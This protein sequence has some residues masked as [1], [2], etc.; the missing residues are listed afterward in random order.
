L[1]EKWAKADSDRRL[2]LCKSDV[3]TRLDHWPT[4]RIDYPRYLRGDD[5]AVNRDAI[6]S[7]GQGDLG[8][9]GRA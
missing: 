5:R 8:V 3:I 4:G 2:S 6:S 7:V 9:W 1:E